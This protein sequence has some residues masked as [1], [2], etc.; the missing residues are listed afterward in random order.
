[1]IRQKFTRRLSVAR[2]VTTLVYALHDGRVLMM[3]RRKQPNLGQWTAPGG[4][5][6]LHESP[7][8]CAVRELAEE[9]GLL[10]AGR[11]ELRLIV[12]ETS[13]L[14][15]WQWLM[16]I[17]LVREFTGELQTD[18]IEGDLAWIPVDQVASLP[19]PQA[20]AIFFPYVVNSS[21][22]PVS[23]KFEYD[24]DLRMEGWRIE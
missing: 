1:V 8:E 15:D 6:E 16:F 13:P 7:A 2:K 11:P 3:H 19:I 12:T 24:A 14:P 22:G 20:D 17:Y 10:A 23:M 5:V 21:P 18:C 4:K 9:T